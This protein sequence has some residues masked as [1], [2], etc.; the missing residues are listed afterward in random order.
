MTAKSAKVVTLWDVQ[1][2]T[3]Q[4]EQPQ[5]S[6]SLETT[7]EEHPVSHITHPPGISYCPKEACGVW[8]L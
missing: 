6:S 7:T 5:Y 3:L 8:H 4:D 2:G 1:Y